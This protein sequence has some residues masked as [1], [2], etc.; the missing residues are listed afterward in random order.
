VV[1]S[2]HWNIDECYTAA[3]TRARDALELRGKGDTLAPSLGTAAVVINA[4]G[5]KAL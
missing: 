2:T 1:R 3:K 4:K 5:M